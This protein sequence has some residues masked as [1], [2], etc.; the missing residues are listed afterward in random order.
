[1]KDKQNIVHGYSVH[2]NNFEKDLCIISFTDISETI[3]KQEA[4]EKKVCS[5]KLTTAY[6]R[7]FFDKNI[8]VILN[9]NDKNNLKT[10]IVMFD[11]DHFK[12]VN[13]TFGHDVGDEVLKEFV[14][15]IKSIS[16]FNDILI[17]WGGEEFLMI[18]SI[19]DENILLKLLEKYRETVSI[20]NFKF[21][22]NITCSI[23]AAVYDGSELIKDTIK[24]A[25]T[26]L[27]EAKN[28]GRN[29]VSIF[30]V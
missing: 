22:G 4:L 12:N 20:N 21:V 5:D 8:E 9:D 16:R 11:I 14:E 2:V 23:G 13:D 27:Y 15:V 1:M 24:K 29:K 3:T 25:D 17:R 6:N 7:E 28:T 26:A 30:K 18:L 10:V 19:K